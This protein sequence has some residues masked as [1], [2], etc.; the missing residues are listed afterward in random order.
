MAADYM[1]IFFVLFVLLPP[2]ME[3]TGGG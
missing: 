1:K 3:G 2:I